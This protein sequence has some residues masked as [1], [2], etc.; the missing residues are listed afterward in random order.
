MTV[1]IVDKEVVSTVNFPAGNIRHK[2]MVLIAVRMISNEPLE[3]PN[4]SKI[5]SDL[6]KLLL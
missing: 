4:L 6:E 1:A 5:I 3:R 2:K